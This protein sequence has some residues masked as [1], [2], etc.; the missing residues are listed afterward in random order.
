MRLGPPA[1]AV[2]FLLIAVAQTHRLA[3]LLAVELVGGA[4]PLRDWMQGLPDSHYQ[5]SA[6][7]VGQ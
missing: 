3:T 5:Q 4:Q 6:Y 7:Q 1:P 2:M